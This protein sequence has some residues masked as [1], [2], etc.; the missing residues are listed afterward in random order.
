MT[1]H[2]RQALHGSL[3][4]AERISE[5]TLPFSDP[6]RLSY[7]HLTTEAVELEDTDPDDPW[8]PVCPEFDAEPWDEADHYLRSEDVDLEDMDRE[9]YRDEARTHWQDNPPEVLWSYVYPV[10]RIDDPNQ[11]AILLRRWTSCVLIENDDTYGIS[12]ACVGMDCSADIALAFVLCGFYPPADLTLPKMAGES[13]YKGPNGLAA[14]C[15]H[16]SQEQL[17]ARMAS[18]S[19]RTWQQVMSGAEEATEQVQ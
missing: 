15:L 5:G 13:Y 6:G 7:D 19:E 14:R 17:M 16:A 18:A 11:A 1:D 4:A 9:D 3:R 8:L 2:I 12:L 10:P